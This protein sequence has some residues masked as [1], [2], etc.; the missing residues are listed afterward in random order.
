MAPTL[1]NPMLSQTQLYGH[2]SHTVPCRSDRTPTWCSKPHVS[3]SHNR[4]CEVN[5]AGL[6]WLHCGVG[7]GVNAAWGRRLLCLSK[8]LTGPASFVRERRR[9]VGPLVVANLTQVNKELC[10]LSIWG[11]TDLKKKSLWSKSMCEYCIHM[12]RVYSIKS[13]VIILNNSY[14]ETFIVVWIDL[15][16]MSCS[17]TRSSFPCLGLAVFLWLCEDISLLLSSYRFFVPGVVR[18]PFNVVVK[19]SSRYGHIKPLQNPAG[20]TVSINY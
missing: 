12:E 6:H 5:Y 4:P 3:T 2:G 19:R 17:Y 10:S 15:W 18:L 13:L 20:N 7:F 14:V 11:Q 9:A 1:S 8:W 16:L